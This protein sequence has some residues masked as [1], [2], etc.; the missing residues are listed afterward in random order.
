ML[1]TAG[2]DTSRLTRHGRRATIETIDPAKTVAAKI[3]AQNPGAVISRR[4]AL[5]RIR[6]AAGDD[7]LRVLPLR[8]VDSGAGLVE[9]GDEPRIALI[10]DD[11]GYDNETLRDALTIHALLNISVLP[12]APN[13]AEAARL[14]NA[15]GFQVLCH[16]PMEPEKY[17]RISPGGEAILT[18]MSDE[19]IRRTAFD[20][21]RLV[22]FAAGAN[23]HMGSK[24]T[25]DPR[26]VRDVMAAMLRAGA[27]FIDSRTSP[28]SVVEP[29]AREMNVP[30]AARDVF[31]DADQNE[32]AI[33]RQLN[34]LASVADA[35]GVAIG[36]GHVHPLTVRILQ[37]E[38]PKLERRGYRFVRA[39][40]VV[41]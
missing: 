2:V 41:E 38:L 15:R 5:I 9:S 14:A 26:V 10:L 16:L 30:T 19:E 6:T 28:R 27:F 32:A 33:V 21:Y 25:S 17:P 31:L 12:N 18:S 20:D 7:L 36:I 35:D 11:A 34:E 40:D 39:G 4:G 8:T 13:A 23:N 1:R 22:P 29:I 24:A 3:E 37:R